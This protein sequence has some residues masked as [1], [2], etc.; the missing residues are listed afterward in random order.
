MNYDWFT[1][2]H[3]SF[4]TYPASFATKV[5]MWLSTSQRNAKRSLSFPDKGK[6][7]FYPYL[8]S[9]MFGRLMWGYDTWSCSSHLV[10]TRQHACAQNINMQR[11]DHV[12]KGTRV[13]VLEDIGEPSNPTWTTCLQTSRYMSVSVTQRSKGLQNLTATGQKPSS[14]TS[15]PMWPGTSLPSMPH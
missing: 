6:S 13:W 9:F 10:T 14:A 4:A 12:Q 1:Q 15:K 2:I 5:V 11:D 7:T 3:L 8:S